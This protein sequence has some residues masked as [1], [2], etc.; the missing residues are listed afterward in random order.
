ML[1][2]LWLVLGL[3]LGTAFVFFARACG[4]RSVFAYGLVVAALIYVAFALFGSAD[5]R[6]ILIEVLGVLVYGVFAALG[7]FR[8]RQWLA[9]GWSVHPVWDLGLQLIG[10]G[11]AFSPAWYAAACISFDL[12]VA[13]YI[14]I[15]S[16]R[17]SGHES[18]PK[19]SD[20]RTRIQRGRGK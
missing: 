16:G 5:S 15:R 7:L 9:L 14:F 19:S 4:E 3:V 6:W 13:A 20:S 8:S 2:A 11:S 17:R 12:L 1:I 18:S 10:G